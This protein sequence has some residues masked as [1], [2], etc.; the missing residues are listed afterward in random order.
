MEPGGLLPQSHTPSTRPYCEPSATS[1]YLAILFLVALIRATCQAHLAFLDLIRL[2]IFGKEYK[3]RS[4]HCAILCIFSLLPFGPKYWPQ[5][6]GVTIVF[7]AVLTN[8][9]VSCR[10][11]HVCPR[12]CR[13][14]Q[15]VF[16]LHGVWDSTRGI[17]CYLLIEYIMVLFHVIWYVLYNMMPLETWAGPWFFPDRW[18][19]GGGSTQRIGERVVPRFCV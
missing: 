12:V 16:Y 7:L 18:S 6:P 5:H 13:R 4:S 1:P 17:A 15:T 8:A 3:L 11:G 10:C 2:V 14:K 9:G 19:G